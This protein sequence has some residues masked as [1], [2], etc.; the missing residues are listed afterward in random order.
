MQGYCRSSTASH[1]IEPSL[2]AFAAAIGVAGRGGPALSRRSPSTIAALPHF[3]KQPFVVL[4]SKD[5]A[6]M[7]AMWDKAII[8]Y[9]GDQCS[10]REESRI[11][12]FGVPIVESRLSA[13]LTLGFTPASASIS[14]AGICSLAVSVQ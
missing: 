6:G 10:L 14:L 7:V 1:S 11:A 12:A 8:R 13:V 4:R 9:G 2:L 5:L 3:R